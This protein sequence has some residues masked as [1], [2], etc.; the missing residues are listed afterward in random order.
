VPLKQQFLQLDPLGTFFIVPSL[1]C[2]LL[3]MQWGSSA[4]YWSNGHIIALLVVYAVLM[5][6]FTLVQIVKNDTA[7]IPARRIKT[8]NILAT[9]ECIF[10]LG[11]A[12]WY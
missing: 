3:A 9:Q 4:Y 8:R 7:T 10:C 1:V 11:C 5:L 6:A 12:S 2:L